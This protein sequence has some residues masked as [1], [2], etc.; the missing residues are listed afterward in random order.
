M[1][2]K[3]VNTT[4]QKPRL[5]LEE[6]PRM[7]IISLEFKVVQLKIKEQCKLLKKKQISNNF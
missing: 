2:L 4:D 7:T 5:G 3:A 1:L 6:L